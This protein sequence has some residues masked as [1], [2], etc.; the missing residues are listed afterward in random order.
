MVEW[1]VNCRKGDN[2]DKTKLRVM[3]KT[4]MDLAALIQD[5]EKCEEKT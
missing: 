5:F 3:T 4:G 2:N 1:T